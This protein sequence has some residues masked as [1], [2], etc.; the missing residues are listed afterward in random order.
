MKEYVQNGYNFTELELN[1]HPNIT[2]TI[3]GMPFVLVR[4]GG[5]HSPKVNVLSPFSAKYVDLMFNNVRI[6]DLK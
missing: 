6:A 2:I 4:D 5:D 3:N 1:D